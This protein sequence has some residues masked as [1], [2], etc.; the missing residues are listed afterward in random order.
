MMLPKRVYAKINLDNIQKNVQSVFDKVGKNVQVMGIVKAD[1]YGHGAVEVSKTLS[2]IGVSAFG[3]AAVS[4]A[5]QLRMNGITKPILIL[6]RAFPDDYPDIVKYD[7][8]LA[9][10]D[11]ECA[12]LLS[13]EA[14][15][16]NKKARVYIKVDTGMGRVGIQP[17][18]SGMDTVKSI[19]ENSGLSVLGAFTHFA[20][21]DEHD[22]SSA[23]NQKKIFLDFTDKIIDMG[24]PLPVRHLYNSASIMELAGEYKGE[25]VRSGI[26]TYGLYPSDEM[27][28]DYELYPALELISHVAFVK[29]VPKGFTVSYGS[30]F[31]TERDTKIATIPVGYADGYPRYLSNKGEVIING[32]RCPIIGKVCMDQ[33]M[34]DVTA[35]PDVK[36]GDR[37]TLIGTDGDETITVDDVANPEYRFNYEL[38]CLINQRVPRVYIKNNEIL[39][40]EYRLA[41]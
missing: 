35:L 12:K 38:C 5:L 16:Q 4:E 34:V 10:F 40:I 18:D 19:F 21:A 33:F 2:E 6:G 8:D 23:E 32:I 20:K 7:I 11:K 26:M 1:A 28:R 29:D 31:T 24:Y 30:T 36:M 3:V 27:N 41:F 15:R 39:K 17:D 14:I 9:V 13:D 25:M 37:V 22:K